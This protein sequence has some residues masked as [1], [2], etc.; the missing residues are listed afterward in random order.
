MTSSSKHP[1]PYERHHSVEGERAQREQGR[2][3]AGE[4][5]AG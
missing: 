2:S 3:Q 4:K 5:L 1:E